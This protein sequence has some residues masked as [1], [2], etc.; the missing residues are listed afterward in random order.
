M[1]R[2]KAETGGQKK[3]SE[4]AISFGKCFLSQQETHSLHLL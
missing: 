4:I 3:K 1:H 2:E